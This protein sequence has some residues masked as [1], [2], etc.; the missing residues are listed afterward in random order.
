MTILDNIKLA[1]PSDEKATWITPQDL[2]EMVEN[3][4]V[5]TDDGETLTAE[6][7]P[8]RIIVDEKVES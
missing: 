1:F 8:F 6:N 7:G 4:E 5:I 2:S 3:G